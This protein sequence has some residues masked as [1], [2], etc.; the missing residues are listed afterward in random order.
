VLALA[1]GDQ[2]RLPVVAQ[3]EAVG[4][5]PSE[6]H[7]TPDDKVQVASHAVLADTAQLLDAGSMRADYA[8]RVADSSSRMATAAS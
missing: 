6:V 1:T 2:E 7:S 8:Q 4:D 3:S 5:K